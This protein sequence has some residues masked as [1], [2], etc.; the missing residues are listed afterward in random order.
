MVVRRHSSTAWH[1]DSL[2]WRKRSE[3]PDS[4]SAVDARRNRVDKPLQT[5]SSSA[6]QT[7]T[8]RTTTTCSTGP[9]RPRQPPRTTR[10]VPARLRGGPTATLRARRT[11]AVLVARTRLSS[12]T[13]PHRT[14]G[15]EWPVRPT[16]AG[17]RRV[18]A[19]L[20]LAVR[21]RPTAR[22][23]C[24]RPTRP[25][26]A[27]QIRQARPAP[28]QEPRWHL[29]R[30][31]PVPKSPPKAHTPRTAAARPTAGALGTRT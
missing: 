19:P 5:S 12:T 8:T 23:R 29:A 22:D 9:P 27:R 14:G 30:P 20:A 13:S 31:L 4:C 24:P 11:V 25:A 6:V 7:T 26:G 18:P 10:A 2:Q 28:Q 3:V 15:V 21:L 17:R 16:R 1:A